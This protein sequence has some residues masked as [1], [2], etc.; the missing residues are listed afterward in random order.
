MPRGDKDKYTDKQK[1][2]AEHI[3]ESYESRGVP[4]DEA[5]ARAW[6]TV[7]KQSGG[8]ER[9][10]GSGRNKSAP[11]KAAARRS[12]AKRAVATKQGVPRPDQP[13]ESMT[14][15]ELLNRART[16]HIAGRSS[17]RKQQLIEALRRAA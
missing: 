17:M 3:E 14:K 9:S 16:R 11:A 5:E 8:G 4:K 6:A 1:R 15:A 2:K 13:L 7:N 12:S 10:G